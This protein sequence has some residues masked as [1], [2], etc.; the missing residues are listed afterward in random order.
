ME[1]GLIVVVLVGA[2]A[3]AVYLGRLGISPGSSP[4][5]E[6]P[7]QPS[8]DA[9][10]SLTGE[11]P[12]AYPDTRLAIG[13][14][15]L[16]DYL[17]KALQALGDQAWSEPDIFGTAY[18]WA[19]PDGGYLLVSAWDDTRR[20]NG[21][22]AVAPAESPVRFSAFGGVVVGASSLREVVTAWGTDYQM[23]SYP[24]EDF[25]VSYVECV[26]PYPVVVKFDQ[27]ARTEDAHSPLPGSP[28]W[29]M[30]VTGLMIAYADEPS[31]SS[32]CPKPA[33]F[34]GASPG[35]IGG[36]ERR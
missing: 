24:Y 35:I 36:G 30:P 15:A 11:T 26:G 22:V 17:P 7:A 8:P 16:D 4:L 33:T 10:Y 32:G 13:F 34:A 3:A 18:T 27:L 14:L 1:V 25:S 28:L 19:F 5:N 29:D 31:G 2:L 6:I 12:Q 21:V 9:Y 23:A 20:V